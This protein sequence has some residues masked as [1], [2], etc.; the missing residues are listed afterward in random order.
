MN[1]IAL[2]LAERLDLDLDHINQEG[3]TIRADATDLVYV[4][5]ES[6]VVMDVEEFRNILH[7]GGVL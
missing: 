4:S 5:W 7:E 6:T 2:A 1:R 3:F